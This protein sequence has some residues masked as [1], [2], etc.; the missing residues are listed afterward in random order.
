MSGKNI[1]ISYRR[2]DA[3]GEAGR[4]A[5]SLKQYFNEDQIFMDVE[6][7]EPGVD[8]VEAINKA[9]SSCDVLLAVIGPRWL[10]ISHSNGQ[11][12]LEDPDD[13]IRLEISAALKRNIRVVPVLVDDASMPTADQLPAELASLVRR[14]AHEISN[15]RWKYD[16]EQLISTLEKILGVSKP[17]VNFKQNEVKPSQKSWLAKNYKWVAGIFILLVLIS[18]LIPEEDPIFPYPEP[19]PFYINNND[20]PEE[21]D[22]LIINRNNEHTNTGEINP[23]TEKDIP[24]DKPVAKKAIS[25][26]DIN[27]IWVGQ[28]LEGETYYLVINQNNN[29][30]EYIE[31]D[32]N[33]QMTGS[34]SGTINENNILLNYT[35]TEGIK[36]NLQLKVSENGEKLDGSISEQ[37]LGLS[38]PVSL[39]KVDL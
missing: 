38:V 37:S 25:N 32:I 35:S 15:S 27:G 14:Q 12:R 33:D 20:G 1:F 24:E 22:Q 18:M 19:D 4:L 34:G 2:Q 16:T 29:N 30:I 17:P 36:V 6:T 13:F 9:V 31:Y 11:R 28:S 7:I 8:F 23:N 3:A 39:T 26:K 10:T 21:D 5:D